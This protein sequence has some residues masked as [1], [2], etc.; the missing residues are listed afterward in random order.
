MKGQQ[1][2]Q[3][4][5]DDYPLAGAPLARPTD[6]IWLQ[7]GEMSAGVANIDKLAYNAVG[8]KVRRA[9]ERTSL[10]SQR[11]PYGSGV[12]S[13]EGWV[14]TT[15]VETTPQPPSAFMPRKAARTRGYASVMPLACGT[16]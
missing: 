5:E 2:M 13:H 9:C 15:P 12:S 7:P 16:W 11:C 14:E 3:T 4:A 6:G 8:G 10:S 1:A